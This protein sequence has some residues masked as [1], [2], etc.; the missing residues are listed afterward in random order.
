MKITGRFKT[1]M[2]RQIDEGIRI[3][4]ENPETLLNSKNEFYGPA[5]KRKILEGKPKGKS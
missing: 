5:V 4:G 1:A 2:N 3:Q